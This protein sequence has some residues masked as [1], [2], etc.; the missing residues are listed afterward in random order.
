MLSRE[1]TVI[2]LD[3]SRYGNEISDCLPRL[4]KPTQIPAS[5]DVCVFRKQRVDECRKVKKKP[6]V[7]VRG[8]LAACLRR[9]ISLENP[10]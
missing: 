5:C 3:S 10:A 1:S 6:G 2:F 4:L 7:R 8:D 9:G